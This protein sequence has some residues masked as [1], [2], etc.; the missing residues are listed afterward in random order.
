MSIN[1]RPHYE[2]VSTDLADWLDRQGDHWWSV[3]GD[4]FLGGRISMPCPGDELAAELR[5]LN[6]PMLVEDRR[7]EPK[8]NGEKIG[9]D[10]LDAL[11]Q[12]RGEIARYVLEEGEEKPLWFGNRILFICWKDRPAECVLKEDLESTISERADAEE[13]A[14]EQSSH[15]TSADSSR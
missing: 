13:Y 14:R 9:P 10:E 5:F 2:I 6:L 3:T 8:G 12:T 11:V 4:W 15:G 1:D 7:R